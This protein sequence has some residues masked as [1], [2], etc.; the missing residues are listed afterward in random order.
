MISSRRQAS[1]I[2]IFPL[3]DTF[4]RRITYKFFV[5]IVIGFMSCTPANKYA[6]PA[7]SKHKLRHRSVSVVCPK[8][9]QQRSSGVAASHSSITGLHPAHTFPLLP[10]IKPA[11]PVCLSRH[12]A[13][14]SGE[15]KWWTVA[16][17]HCLCAWQCSSQ[18]PLC[19]HQEMSFSNSFSNAL[20][21]SLL[22]SDKAKSR[23]DLLLACA[24]TPLAFTVFHRHRHTLIFLLQKLR[25][26]R[27]DDIST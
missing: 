19:S 20:N 13:C 5:Y 23:R 1:V 26:Y 22:S 15:A 3:S 24:S 10:G 17:S 21:S 25:I 2:W 18:P 27:R 12:G 4:K 6:F 11:T 7:G 14:S 9:L 8:A 16:V